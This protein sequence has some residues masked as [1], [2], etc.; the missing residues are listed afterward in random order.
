MKIIIVVASLCL[1]ITGCTGLSVGKNMVKKDDVVYEIA[2]G[3]NSSPNISG[4][5]KYGVNDKL[6][7]DMNITSPVFASKN[8]IM[9]EPAL[10][11]NIIKQNGKRPTLNGYLSFPTLYSLKTSDI[12]IYPVIGFV[13]KY[14]GEKWGGYMVFEELT[15]FRSDEKKV[16][17]KTNIKLGV[18]YKIR[19]KWAL[20]LEIGVN[21]IGYKNMM[22][23]FG[24]PVIMFGTTIKQ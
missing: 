18:E 22:A 7:L 13:P 1:L 16:S 17:L 3:M 20:D 6:N 12:K 2:V 21:N 11:K 15:E 10:V 19:E 24:Y 5:V 4:G 9:F 14:E 23:D 8:I